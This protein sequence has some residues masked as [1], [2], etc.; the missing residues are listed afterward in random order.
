MKHFICISKKVVEQSEN[1]VRLKK[2]VNETKFQINSITVI[3]VAI[4]AS[5]SVYFCYIF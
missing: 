3:K 4:E 2:V 5:Q 1:Y